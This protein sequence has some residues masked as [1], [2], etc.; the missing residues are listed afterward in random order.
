MST[1]KKAG[2]RAA[3]IQPTSKGL[4]EM[5]GLRRT[6][7]AHFSALYLKHATAARSIAKSVIRIGDLLLPTISRP[8]RAEADRLAAEVGNPA[9]TT[10]LEIPGCFT[11]SDSARLPAAVAA[12]LRAR[13]DLAQLVQA[14]TESLA[15]LPPPRRGPATGQVGLAE[16][17]E[18]TIA[19]SI[20]SSG[21]TVQLL[22][23]GRLA[24]A[25]RIE[26]ILAPAQ[27]ADAIESQRMQV[28]Q[29]LKRLRAGAILRK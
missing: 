25:A 15:R 7:P 10:T 11:A 16:W 21:P 26:G 14:A 4:L 24:E 3:P 2:L 23:P 20:A 29:A 27:N 22:D 12:L 8:E 19:T 6:T 28:K 1:R 17:L 13:D 5:H 18:S 9:A